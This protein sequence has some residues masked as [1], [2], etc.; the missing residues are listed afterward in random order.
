MTREAWAILLGGAA[1]AIAVWAWFNFDV[2]TDRVYVGYSGEAA[3]NPMLAF[4]RFVKRMGVQE[5]V[6]EHAVELDRLP[7]DATLIISRRRY[8]MTPQRVV[9]LLAWVE[10][11]GRL[12]V[13]AEAIGTRDPLL[14][15]L[16]V[17]RRA[18]T[19]S[20]DGARVKL[21]G[22]EPAFKVALT[23]LL[24]FGGPANGYS[25]RVGDAATALLQFR[26]GRGSVVVLPS[27]WF[28]DNR[29][30]GDPDHAAFAWA[31]IRLANDGLPPSRMVIAPRFERPSLLA[32][33]VGPALP[34]LVA[35]AALLLLWLARAIP[36]FGPVV[37]AQEP[38][39]RRLLDHLRAS[40]RFEWSA[41]AA[42]RLIAAAREGC[43]SNIAKARPA[44]G[45]LDA[46][47]RSAQFAALTGLPQREVELAFSAEITTPRSFIDAVQTLQAIEEKLARRTA[48]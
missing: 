1:L 38:A 41:H 44:L 7:P 27:L 43:L 30:I 20:A 8:G 28:V 24:L 40:G 36:R 12:I 39:R 45:V 5:K 11:G 15:A 9:G 32:W 42:A 13:E 25:V 17:G 2:V 26:K 19:G 35:A 16:Q 21:D 31:V 29:H 47:E 18:G 46:S 37:S 3:R 6:V 23:P 10:R 34:A 48:A 22:Y 33:L 4:E 14:D